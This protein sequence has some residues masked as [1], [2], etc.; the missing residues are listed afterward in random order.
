MP[1]ESRLFVKTS[2]IALVAAF[3]WGAWMAFAE[4]L[5]R[6][7]DPV[8]PIEHAHLAFVGWLVNIVVGI[9]I[10]LLPLNRQRYAETQG[11]YFRWMP[12]TIYVL[13]NAGLLARIFSEPFAG[14]N[15]LARIVLALSAV[16]QVLAIALF[17]ALALS[18]TRPP[19]HPAPG[20]R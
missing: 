11:R 6:P 12:L 18:R 17:A 19:S 8:W 16:A 2:L 14:V 3:V 15:A 13:L 20:T 4:S 10:W 9:A 1:F 7:I 5:G